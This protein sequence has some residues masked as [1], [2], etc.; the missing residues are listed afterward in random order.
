MYKPKPVPLAPSE[1]EPETRKN[2]VKSLGKAS[3]GMPNPVS[4]TLN[5]IDLTGKTKSWLGKDNII[6]FRTKKEGVEVSYSEINLAIVLRRNS[7]NTNL[8]SIHSVW[9]Q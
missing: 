5:I 6:Y 4:L 3:A 1:R 2:L 7:A 9:S 8:T